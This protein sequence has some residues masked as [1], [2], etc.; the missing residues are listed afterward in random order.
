MG[1]TST[2]TLTLTTVGALSNAN[3]NEMIIVVPRVFEGLTSAITA[4]IN[5]NQYQNVDIYPELYTIVIHM[6]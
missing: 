3:T 1:A 2:L 6:P 5:G 4:E